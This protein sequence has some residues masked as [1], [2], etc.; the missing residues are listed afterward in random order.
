[1]L[2]T[3]HPAPWHAAGNREM[4]DGAG[5][6]VQ[7]DQ[8]TLGVICL[9]VN[10]H[11]RMREVLVQISKIAAGLHHADND[12]A[13]QI[14]A[15]VS[16]ALGRVGLGVLV[17]AL[18][19]A[20]GPDAQLDGMIADELQRA[21]MLFTSDMNAAMQLLP[22]GWS[23]HWTVTTAL[24]CGQPKFTVDLTNPEIARTVK[25]TAPSIALAICA[26]SLMA[27]ET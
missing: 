6:V 17:A 23:V 8:E 18:E 22:A 24:D 15:L 16:V 5:N 1:M 20:N 2:C 27:M 26:A 11:D 10:A 12:D 14:Q 13:A 3:K 25:A 7:Y 21:P 19:A 9:A 4:G